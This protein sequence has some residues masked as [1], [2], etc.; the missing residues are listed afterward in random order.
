M[1]TV[2]FVSIVLVIWQQGQ[3]AE[4]SKC[5]LNFISVVPLVQAEHDERIFGVWYVLLDD[6][7]FEGCLVWKFFLSRFSLLGILGR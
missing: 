7:S 3:L 1:V 6:R 5:I 2:K 4:A